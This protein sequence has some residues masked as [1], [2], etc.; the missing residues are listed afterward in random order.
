MQDI[1]VQNRKLINIRPQTLDSAILSYIWLLLFP[2]FTH[3]KCS[4]SH[5]DFA[6]IGPEWHPFAVDWQCQSWRP[7]DPSRTWSGA[8]LW[9]AQ[10]S[11]QQSFSTTSALLNLLTAEATAAH[12]SQDTSY[13][14]IPRSGESGD[15]VLLLRNFYRRL[16]LATKSVPWPSDRL[17]ELST[18][19]WLCGY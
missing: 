5:T 17:G 2:S 9:K 13:E 11:F 12:A 3:P 6:G 1:L 14:G 15:A 16:K 8:V 4:M 19:R 18:A 7:P 10:Q